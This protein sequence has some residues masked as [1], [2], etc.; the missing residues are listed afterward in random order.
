MV[1]YNASAG[2]VTI[3]QAAESW[4]P[5]QKYVKN[6]RIDL[7]DPAALLEYNRGILFRLTGFSIEV[8][9]GNLIPSICLRQ[10]YIRI[11]E[12][13]LPGVRTVV[14]VGTGA[15]AIL[16]LLAANRGYRVLATEIDQR[17]LEYAQKNSEVND[18]QIA[19]YRSTG[20]ILDG[21]LPENLRGEIDLSMTYPPF[22]PDDRPGYTSKKKRGFGGTD[23]ELFGG[24]TGI[25]FI[26]A[27][28]EDCS[29][30]RIKYC[31]LMVH[32]KVVVE[33]I[34]KIFETLGH[35]T[36]VIDVIAGRRR[37]YLVIGYDE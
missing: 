34:I 2:C 14:D 13:R 6:G 31:T 1:E 30:F 32:K 37:R 27:Y 7:G 21:V 8:P 24:R 35:R 36:E 29:I 20:G 12:D 26:R 28:I 25:E 5:L 3:E 23:S 16:A 9:R 11:I 19:F 22:Y 15:S 18:Q 17:S 33:N 4:E 10:T